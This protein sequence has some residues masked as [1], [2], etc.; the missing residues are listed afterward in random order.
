MRFAIAAAIAIAAAACSAETTTGSVAVDAETSASE[1]KHTPVAQNA[2]NARAAAVLIRADWCSSCKLLEPKLDVVKSLGPIEG[3]EHV[4]LD[5]TARDKK[6]F[7]AAADA[8]GVGE[9]VRAELGD[10]VTT[11]IILVVDMDDAKVVA[12]L[13]KE[14]SEQEL[15]DAMAEAARAS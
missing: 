11:G 15:V 2:E 14:L 5:Y 3:L 1:L 6:A 4:T 12:D 10:S 8:A 9:A 13:R 7:F